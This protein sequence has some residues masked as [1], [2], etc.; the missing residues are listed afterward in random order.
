MF[1][2]KE[3]QD[4]A[5]LIGVV[6]LAWN[7][8]THQLL[9]IFSHLTG[10]E[11]PL[12]DAIFFSPQSDSLQRNMIKRV[13]QAVELNKASFDELKTLLHRL[14]KA[15]SGRNLAAHMIFGI[16]AFDPD[17]GT[18]GAKVVP[19]LRPSQ[20]PRLEADFA[21]QFKRVEEELTAIYQD[22][23][24]WLVHTP[25]PDRPWGSPPFPKAAANIIAARTAELATMI[26]ESYADSPATDAAGG[27]KLGPSDS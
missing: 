6:T 4:H 15:S 17:T 3:W 1:G 10:L 18:W 13:A 21:A 5:A 16:S 9:R 2:Q 7:Q 14:Q 27:L 12:A 26:N 22:L 23:E 24:H 11:S 8:N 25:F 19:A 20:D